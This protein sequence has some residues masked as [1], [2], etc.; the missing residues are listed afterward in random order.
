MKN[1][2]HLPRNTEII[3]PPFHY[4]FLT[5]PTQETFGIQNPTP[6]E[7]TILQDSIRIQGVANEGTVF[8]A[9]NDNDAIALGHPIHQ[10][11]MTNDNPQNYH[12]SH[13]TLLYNYF[14]F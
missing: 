3:N 4:F 8:G 12:G 9:S 7:A 2:L 13:G 5:A 6:L 10:Q 14:Y 11:S 1:F